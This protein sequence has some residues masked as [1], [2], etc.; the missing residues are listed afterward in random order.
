MGVTHGWSFGAIGA[1]VYAAWNAYVNVQQGDAW[2]QNIGL[3]A[4]LIG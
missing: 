2:Y 1:V 3:E 4:R